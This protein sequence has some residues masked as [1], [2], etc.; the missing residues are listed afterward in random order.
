MKRTVSILT[1]VATLLVAPALPIAAADHEETLTGNFMSG[2][3]DRVKP[4]RAVFTPGDEADFDVV[5]YFK[6]NGRDHEYRGTARGA[7][8]EGELQGRVQNESLQRTFTFRGTFENGVLKGTH[9]EVG[10]KGERKT[11]TLTLEMARRG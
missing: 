10:R 5:F 3:Q 7:L 4:L 1:T 6:F 9:A 2:Y 11:G 8:G